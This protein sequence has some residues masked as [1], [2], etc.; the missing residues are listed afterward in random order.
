MSYDVDSL[1][2]KFRREMDDTVQPYLWSEDDIVDYL[3]QAEDEFADLADAIN[4]QIEV[5]YLADDVW[6]NI[7]GYVTRVR[8]AENADDADVPLYNHEEW[9]KVL[10]TD[11]YGISTIPTGWKTKTGAVP[12]ALV[13][14]TT[15]AAR[16]YPI[17]TEDGAVTLTIFRRTLK[18]LAD[19]GKFEVTDRRHQ[20]CFLKLAKALAYMKHDAEA[21]NAQ[22]AE[23]YEA[24]F[25][26]EVEE[27]KSRVSRARRRAGTTTYGG[28]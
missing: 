28:L 8:Q 5:T 25:R 17:P 7:P 2:A 6:L 23:K 16:M 22:L 9:Q 24:E 13:T 26:A 18:H 19:R 11:D 3:D 4:E 27:L 10:S 12:V 1:V 15:G 21:F 20:R 14:D